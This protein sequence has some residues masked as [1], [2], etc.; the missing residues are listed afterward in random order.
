MNLGEHLKNYIEYIAGTVKSKTLYNYQRIIDLHINLSLGD[1]E[2]T[3]LDTKIIQDFIYMLG[4]NG[5]KKTNKGL[6]QNM[7]SMV[8]TVLKSCMNYCIGI[9]ALEF[10]PCD[11]VRKPKSVPKKV[12]NFTKL[13]QKKIEMF[14]HT[15][16]KYFGVLLALYTGLRI[17]ELLALTWAD[18]DRKENI[19]K[20]TKT[21][22]SLK[23]ENGK[24]EQ[25]ID[26]PK[27]TSS[28]REIPVSAG[29]KRL[30]LE[31]K[32]SSTSEYI[33]DNKGKLM[34]IRHYQTIFEYMLKK[35]KIPKKGFH[36]LRHTFATRAVEMGVEIKTL[37]ELLGHSNTSITLN[38]YVHTNMEQ[39]KKAINLISKLYKEE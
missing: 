30:L 4:K 7:I 16:R 34:R 32:K 1:Y 11:G 3:K 8:L 2:I 35:L 22:Y 18:F 26:T 25:V 9:K 14:S 20:I 15:N 21:T 28:I 13:E 12:E 19:L 24:W 27:T 17:G 36:S 38:R 33:I 10:N 39:K 37:S 6:S 5:N 29:I 23:K 31:H